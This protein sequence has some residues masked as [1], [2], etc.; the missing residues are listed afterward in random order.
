MYD[1]WR[2]CICNVCRKFK[3]TIEILQGDIETLESEKMMAE[4][5]LDQESK[6]A[7][8]AE[9]STTSRRLRGSS[10]G[11]ALG[12]REG[13]GGAE[14]AVGAPQQGAQPSMDGAA[15]PLLLARVGVLVCV[16]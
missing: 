14:G 13:R 1:K 6:K 7:I 12:L 15:S 16:M 10:F 2:M 5:K 11:N 4:R 8:L 9:T 3:K